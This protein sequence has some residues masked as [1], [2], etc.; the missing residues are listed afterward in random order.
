MC[1]ITSS[2]DSKLSK[3]SDYFNRSDENNKERLRYFDAMRGFAI[4]FGSFYAL[5]GI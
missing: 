2:S 4:F 5:F 3:R 1:S